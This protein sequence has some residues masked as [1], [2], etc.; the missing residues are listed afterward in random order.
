MSALTR[1]HTAKHPSWRHLTAGVGSFVLVSTA[2]VAGTGS[3]S[4]ATDHDQSKAAARFLSGTAGGTDL[5]TIAALRGVAVHNDG[6]ADPVVE[7]N[8]L[9]LSLLGTVDIPVPGGVTVP[10]GQLMSVGAVNQY[11][12][13]LPQGVSRSAAGAVA[14]SGAVNT[15]GG[16]SFPADASVSLAPLLGTAPFSGVLADVDVTLRGISAVAA[17]D[18]ASKDDVAKTCTDL[19]DPQQCRDYTI[20][21]GNLVIDAPGLATLAS[22]L[23]GTGPVA[24]SVDSAIAQLTGNNGALAQVLA[25]LNPAL[26][27]VAGSSGLTVTVTSDVAGAL[28]TVTQTPISD[29]VVSINLS[30]GKISVDLEKLTGTSL[31]NLPPNTEIISGALLTDLVHRI[32]ALLNEVP[33]TVLDAVTTALDAAKLTIAGDVC[34]VPGLPGASCLTGINVDVKGTL[35]QVKAGTATTT[36][37]VRVL[38]AAVAVPTSTLLTGLT[39]PINTALATATSTAT[40]TTPVTTAVA[41][42]TGALAPALSALTGVI[43]LRA[44]VQEAGPEAGSYREVA[45]RA[46]LLGG[47]LATVDLARAEVGANLLGTQ[48]EQPAVTE[49]PGAQ[50]G[51]TQPG[52]NR[53]G[54]TLPDTGAPPDAPLAL[55]GALLLLAGAGLVRRSRVTA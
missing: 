13:A 22:L 12:A 55:L 49:T 52:A 28:T 47:Q 3:A 46:S 31:D 20:A 23:G 43:S 48:A 24:T 30:T 5:D 14:N 29:G 41:S 26:A 9:D 44:N 25:G 35:A 51:T 10:L 37:A 7:A 11:A 17:L 18:A 38:G 54:T 34:V 4:A 27:P 19:A 36:L 8:P 53:P 50:P 16:G 42:I 6:G 2:V 39:G 1:I 32:S 45:V 40:I 21:G 15:N 33:A